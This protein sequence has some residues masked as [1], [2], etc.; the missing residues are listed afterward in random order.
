[1]LEAREGGKG[2]VVIGTEDGDHNADE[3]TMKTPWMRE[4]LEFVTGGMAGAIR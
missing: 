2:K 3:V 1:M 4:G